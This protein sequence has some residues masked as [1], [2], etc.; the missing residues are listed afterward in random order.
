[1]N[2]PP[3]EIP[4]ECRNE[5]QDKLADPDFIFMFVD[6]IFECWKDSKRLKS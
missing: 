6:Y 1:M 2:Q 3:I 5:V 4:E